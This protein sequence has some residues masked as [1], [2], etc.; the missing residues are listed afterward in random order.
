M[1]R[2][3]YLIQT[4][5]CRCI[6]YTGL[7]HTP[8][9]RCMPWVG[10]TPREAVVSSA[11]RDVETVIRGERT[12]YSTKLNHEFVCSTPKRTGVSIRR[13]CTTVTYTRHSN[14]GSDQYGLVNDAF[15]EYWVWW[16]NS[17][18]RSSMRRSSTR[19]SSTRRSSTRRSSV[20]DVRSRRHAGDKPLHSDTRLQRQRGVTHTP[21]HRDRPTLR[22]IVLAGSVL[23]GPGDR[24]PWNDDR[25]RRVA[26]LRAVSITR[27]PSTHDAIAH[28]NHTIA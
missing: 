13:N 18:R 1:S 26:V 2:R 24:R 16:M 5:D 10:S 22:I 27:S 21:Q 20:I 7:S 6:V 12:E 14:N 23:V 28:L 8:D 3:I 11:K 4:P 15:V 9:C 19:R 17:T 25:P